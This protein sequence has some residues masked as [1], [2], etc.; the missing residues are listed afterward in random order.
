[1]ARTTHI[2]QRE[3]HTMT[4]LL[5]CALSFAPSAF[6]FAIHLCP[7]NFGSAGHQAT[8]HFKYQ[9]PVT[10]L[11]CAG[12]PAM[13]ATKSIV[14]PK[15]DDVEKKAKKTIKVKPSSAASGAAWDGSVSLESLR[16]RQADFAKERTWD[17]HHTP[18]NLALAM[19]GEVGELC[20]CFQWR[21]DAS[22]TV[23]LPGWSEADREHLG[24]EMSDVLLYLVRL[25]D[26]CDVNLA[27]A[28]SKKIE[29]N[30]AKYPAHLVKGS[31]AKYTAYSG[32]VAG[33][34]GVVDTQGG[35]TGKGKTRK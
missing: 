8:Q 20:E 25:A 24:E 26:K 10:I 7:R 19:V 17:Q 6:G 9:W 4:T 35:V 16:V 32:L 33:A 21:P 29:K 11:M 3:K 15:T 18:R 23:G 12:K 28:V 13:K 1:M 34:G 31:S 2:P 22:T 5:L 14:K 27:E 30:A